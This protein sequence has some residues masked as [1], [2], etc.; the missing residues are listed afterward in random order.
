MTLDLLDQALARMRA[1][2][3][4]DGREPIGLMEM[5]LRNLMALDERVD[6]ADFLARMDTLRVMG[7]TVMISNYSRFHNVTTYLRRYTKDRIGMVLGVPT[8]AQ[9]FEEKHYADLD[10]GIL[11]ALGR[12]V[13]GGPVKLY[14]YPFHD[15]KSGMSVTA[16]TFALPVHLS[17]LYAHLREDGRIVAIDPG[18]GFDSAVLPRDVLALLRAGNP[19]WERH[20][21]EEA[22]RLIKERRLFGYSPPLARR[23]AVQRRRVARAALQVARRGGSAPAEP[24]LHGQVRRQEKRGGKHVPGACLTDDPGDGNGRDLDPPVGRGGRASPLPAMDDHGTGTPFPQ[25]PHRVFRG[26]G[27][28]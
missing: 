7:R 22:G 3:G 15:P 28:P 14:V 5:T 25:E 12:L 1:E 27:R 11:E 6:H 4:T 20:V 23:P 13:G 18:P 10:G 16:E 8:L 17:H 24:L 21:P 19:A 26:F 9:I 2:P